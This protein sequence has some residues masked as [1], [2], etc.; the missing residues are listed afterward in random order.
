MAENEKQGIEGTFS[1]SV[2]AHVHV[3]RPA[4]LIRQDAYGRNEITQQIKL[5]RET[6]G[7]VASSYA[8]TALAM[9]QYNEM[10]YNH[11][12]EV[13]FGINSDFDV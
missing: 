7:A 8:L 4:G 9:I 1:G 2:G 11:W 3:V 5:A 13:Y 6:E 12:D 10:L